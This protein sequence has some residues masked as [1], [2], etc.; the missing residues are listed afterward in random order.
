MLTFLLQNQVKIPIFV[1]PLAAPVFGNLQLS[2]I[3]INFV[4]L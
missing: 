2:E 1:I 4:I 3:K